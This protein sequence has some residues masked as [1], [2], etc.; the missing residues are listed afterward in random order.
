MDKDL[1]KKIEAKLKEKKTRLEKEL[2]SFAERDVKMVGDYDTRFPDFGTTQSSDEEAIEVATYGNSL[3][4]EYALELS[5]VEVG[6]AL[7][8]IKQGTYGNCEKCNQSIDPK[9]LE[10][11]PEA[12]NCVKCQK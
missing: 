5:L 11:M 3:P 2:A 1:L 10:V 6:K 12:K 4:V 7:E 8:K 9:R